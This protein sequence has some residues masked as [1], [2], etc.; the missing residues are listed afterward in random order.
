MKQDINKQFNV[1]IHLIC[2]KWKTLNLTCGLLNFFRALYLHDPN[3]IQPMANQKKSLKRNN[4]IASLHSL[5]EIYLINLSDKLQGGKRWHNNKDSN[6]KTRLW[7]DFF[8]WGRLWTS[9]W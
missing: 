2:K 3:T 7:I 4:H 8:L 6:N 1:E 5:I 9:V